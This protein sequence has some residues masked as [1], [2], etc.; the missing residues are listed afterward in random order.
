MGNKNNNNKSMENDHVRQMVARTGSGRHFIV[1]HKPSAKRCRP[2]SK[3]LLLLLL[4]IVR[5]NDAE[6]KKDK[7]EDNGKDERQTVDTICGRGQEEEMEM[8]KKTGTG[9]GTNPAGVPFCVSLASFKRHLPVILC[10]VWHS[11]PRQNFLLANNERGGGEANDWNDSVISLALATHCQYICSR[12]I[13]N[14]S[15]VPNKKANNFSND[16]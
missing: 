16:Q 13:G 1:R 11:F 6:E 12:C 14:A 4:R 15:G 2:T 3:L 8:E 10:R 9:T 5:H 7:A